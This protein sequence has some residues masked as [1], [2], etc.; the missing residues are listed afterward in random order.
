MTK[1]P[2]LLLTPLTP[3]DV[4]NIHI[5]NSFP[6]VTEFNTIG[7]PISIEDTKQLLEPLFE[8]QNPEKG[9]LVG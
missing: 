2:R 8:T 3:N 1:T 5:K 9:Q 7:I 4:E 6:E